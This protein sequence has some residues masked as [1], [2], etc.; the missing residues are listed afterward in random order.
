MCTD[1][2]ART[3]GDPPPDLIDAQVEAFAREMANTLYQAALRGG[4]DPDD[5]LDL[6]AEAQK[7]TREEWD[8][9]NRE[10]AHGAR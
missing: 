4:Q 2:A 9:V 5:A 8:R 6:A 1:E 3:F 7:R 10:D